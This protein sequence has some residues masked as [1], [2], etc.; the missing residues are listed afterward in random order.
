MIYIVNDCPKYHRLDDY[1][2]YISELFV[3][4]SEAVH[5]KQARVVQVVENAI[6]QIAW[7]LLLTLASDLSGR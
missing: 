3:E 4:T 1:R 5:N 7:F 2:K 6:Q